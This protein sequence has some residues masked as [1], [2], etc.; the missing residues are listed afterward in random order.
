VEKDKIGSLPF[1]RWGEEIAAEF[2][3][4]KGFRILE[5]HFIFQH[6]EI[7]LV[8]RDG[9]YLVFVEVK[10]R[11]SAEY[12]L[13]EEALSERKKRYLKKAAEG[14][15]YLNQLAD[16]DCRFDVVTVHFL[17]DGTTSLNHYI[18]AFE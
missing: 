15:L 4:K 7:D 16:Q 12:G 10:T 6:A 18:N 1:G 11:S 9:S 8:A 13:P 5:R 3:E 2:L 17:P 14:Y